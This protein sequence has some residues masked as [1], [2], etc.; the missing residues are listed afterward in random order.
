M[1]AD[2]Y[3]RNRPSGSPLRPLIGLIVLILVGGFSFLV[4][5]SVI[6]WLTT[7]NVDFVGRPVLPITFPADWPALVV[8]LVVAL[9]L[10]IVLFSMSMILMMAIMPAPRGELD[11]DAADVRR[12]K[13]AQRKYRKS[14][15]RR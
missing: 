11:V 2:Y 5:P 10:F 14:G 7:A 12:E 9:I 15:R 13:E 3:D 4:A 6:R 8:Q 1:S